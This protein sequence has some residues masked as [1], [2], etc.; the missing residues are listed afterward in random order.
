MQEAAQITAAP[1]AAPPSPAAASPPPPPGYAEVERRLHENLAPC[2]EAALDAARSGRYSRV[3]L[4]GGRGS[5]KSSAASLIVAAGLERDERACALVLRKVGGTLRGSVFEQMRWALETLGVGERWESTVAPMACERAQT[6]QRILFRGLDEPRKIK[7]IKLRGGQYFALVWFEELDEYEG[8]QE[9][10]SVLDSALRGGPG[11]VMLG[12]Y[13]PPKSANSWVNRMRQSP[14]SGWFVHHSDYT[15]IPPDW[16][17]PVFVRRAAE[18]RARDERAYRHTYLGECTGEGGAVF[19]NLRLK[20]IPAADRQRF[21]Q[22]PDIGMDFGYVDPSA[23]VKTYYEPG[24]LRALYVYEE[25]YRSGQTTRQLAAACK[26][27]ARRGELICADN[28]ARQTVADLRAE[29]GVHIAGAPKGPGSRAG[30]YDWLRGLDL[31]VVDPVTCPNAAREFSAY[32]YARARDGTLIERYP[33]GND[34]TIDAVAYGNRRNI[35]RG[36]RSRNLG[37][38]RGR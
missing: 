19:T 25:F 27:I 38:K 16:L 10:D 8:E 26:A 14:P 12:T 4:D 37:G 7:S 5:G 9:I 15:M 2:F 17:G 36:S 1:G 30:G 20:P 34:H 24:E 29:Y 13:N 31:I 28:A 33:D 23:I 22:R 3:L 21:E 6:G 11:G 32:E 18:M 35:L